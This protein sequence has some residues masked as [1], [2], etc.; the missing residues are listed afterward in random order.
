MLRPQRELGPGGSQEPAVKESDGTQ[1]PRLPMPPKSP[2]CVSLAQF[3]V[4]VY[5]TAVRGV[6]EWSQSRKTHTCPSFGVFLT[7]WSLWT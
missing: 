7:V 4:C 5:E 1:P 2:G 6:S 3:G